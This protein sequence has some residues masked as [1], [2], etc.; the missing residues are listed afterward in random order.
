VPSTP[1]AS[2]DARPAHP[3]EMPIEALGGR[4][5]NDREEDPPDSATDEKGQ[6][7]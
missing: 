4:P 3:V 2:E 6:S 7:R 1:A 5:E